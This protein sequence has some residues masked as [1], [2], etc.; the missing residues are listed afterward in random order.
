MLLGDELPNTPGNPSAVP[1]KI[2][3][4]LAATPTVAGLLNRLADDQAYTLALVAALRPDVVAN[5][6]RYHR[7]GLRAFELT[8]HVDEHTGQIRA[9]LAAG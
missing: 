8:D 2:A 3:A 1:E 7:I 9:A 4:A 6:A 5:K